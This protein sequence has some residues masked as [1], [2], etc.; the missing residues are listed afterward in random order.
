[1]FN[2]KRGIYI[3]KIYLDHSATTYMR[4]EVF[5][6]ITPYFE[7]VY[8]NPSS[9]HTA[10]LEAKRAL[11]FSRESV[12]KCLNCN[13]DE[14]IF[15]GSGTESCNLAIKGIAFALQEAGKHII[16]QKTEHHAVLH[17]L[18]WLEKNFGFEIT[19]LDVD[20][21]GIISLEDLKNAI[22]EDTILISIMYAN[23]EIGTIQPIKGIGEIAK[24]HNV[25]FH[26]DACQAGGLMEIDVQNLGV[27]LMTLNGSKIYGMKGT[28]LLFKRKGIKIEPWLHGGAHEFGLRAGTE[29]I[30]GIVGLAKALSIG[31]AEREQEGKRLIELRDYLIKNILEKIPES[32]LNGHPVKR[33]PNNI[34][35]SFLNVEGEALILMLDNEG[36]YASSGS[37][38][39]SHSLKPSHVILALGLPYEASHGAIRFSLGKRTTKEDIDYVIEKLPGIIER[40]RGISP[41]HLTKAEVLNG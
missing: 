5:E 41:I 40:L 20:D 12:S 3:K 14:I 27:D 7:E 19:L 24:K 39:T 36:I 16:S 32:F 29:N 28:G 6:A 18:E 1:L 10:G 26:T 35:I 2:L 8:G 11:E 25:L 31:Q 15:T 37:A 21:Y 30:P 13:P 4:P 9:F 33:L 34:N 23:N 38:C 17:S 22:R